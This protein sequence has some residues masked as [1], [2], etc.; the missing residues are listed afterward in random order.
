MRKLNL[1][2]QRFGR[3]V[4]IKEAGR[5]S[6]GRVRWL[7]KCDCGNYTSTPST[8]TL[9]NGTCRSCGCIEKEKPNSRTHGM[10]NTK[11]FAVWNS[12][13][14][15]CLNQNSK[16]YKNY[17]GRGITVCQEWQEDFQTFY[18]WAMANG[19]QEGLEIDR[20]YVNGNY[21]PDNCRWVTS[22][23]NNNNRRNNAKIKIGGEEHTAA[24]W[25]EITG[26]HR[27]TILDRFNSGKPPEEILKTK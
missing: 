22:K 9:R 3:L 14:Q 20:I 12:M 6:D 1:T 24:E 4:V 8:K 21:E 5:S 2:G 27:N 23:K 19:Y 7:C 13:K 17:G 11:L 26:I 18:D 15:R 10:S 16:S 25:S